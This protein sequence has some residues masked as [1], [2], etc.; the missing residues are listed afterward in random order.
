M[1]QL[2]QNMDIFFA[3]GQENRFCDF[4]LKPVGA[5][6]A[7]SRDRITSA[8]SAKPLNCSGDRFTAMRA[9]LA[10]LAASA[11]ARSKT[12]LP[13]GSISPDD[14]AMGMNSAGEISPRVG[15]CH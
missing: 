1:L 5:R 10:Q 15:C 3:V 12:H 9:L 7:W 13:M 14:S 11:Q 8:T 4:K 2:M 6:P